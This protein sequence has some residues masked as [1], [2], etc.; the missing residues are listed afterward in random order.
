MKADQKSIK[1]RLLISIPLF[2]VGYL[3]TLV[4]FGV[5]WRYFAWTNQTLATV[6]LWTV[7]VYLMREKKNFWLA[8]IP[9]TFMTAVVV[10]YIL[11][12]PEG[13]SLPVE[14]S[15]FAGMTVS[16]GITVFAIFK[17]ARIKRVAIKRV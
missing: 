11:L 9:S 14:M 15:I 17:N 3:L 10:S 8:L 12:A 13:F 2:V 6:V 1:N 7:T 5:I 4:N 16:V